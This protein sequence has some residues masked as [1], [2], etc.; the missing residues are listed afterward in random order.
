[1]K[2]KTTSP[3]NHQQYYKQQQQS[4]QPKQ[5]SSLPTNHQTTT[6]YKK[7][8]SRI[9]RNHQIIF[10]INGNAT[11]KLTKTC[12]YLVVIVQGIDKEGVVAMLRCVER[13]DDRNSQ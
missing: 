13:V 2:Q 12:S 5:C 6:N 4:L 10:S 9:Q 7:A 1:M 8:T 11:P 3:T